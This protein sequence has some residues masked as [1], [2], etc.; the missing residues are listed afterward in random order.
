MQ[1]EVA[2]D[3]VKLARSLKKNATVAKEIIKN[4]NQVG[5]EISILTTINYHTNCNGT[6][7]DP[8]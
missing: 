5:V 4:D 1:E 8:I 2:E 7:H 3:M 6:T